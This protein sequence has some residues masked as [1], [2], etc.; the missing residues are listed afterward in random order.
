MDTAAC[1]CGV[2]AFPTLPATCLS[3][4]RRLELKTARP[5]RDPP[6]PREDKGRRGVQQ[7]QAVIQPSSGDVRAALRDTERW[8]PCGGFD[9]I[10]LTQQSNCTVPKQACHKG[11]E[12][13]R[14]TEGN[15]DTQQEVQSVQMEDFNFASNDS[16]PHNE[17]GGLFP[18][19]TASDERQQ[20]L[21][22]EGIE[23][24]DFAMSRSRFSCLRAAVY[25]AP[26]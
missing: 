23:D 16:Q 8:A 5:L 25:N 10:S 21:N 15:P 7:M 12:R 9:P 18:F 6:P 22:A 1:G 14:R 13:G 11:W 2:V 3:T 17:R 24:N 19:R 4:H 26:D 20:M